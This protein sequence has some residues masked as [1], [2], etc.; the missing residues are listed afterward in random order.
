LAN[1]IEDQNKNEPSEQTKL[2]TNW[3]KVFD[4]IIIDVKEVSRVAEK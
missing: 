4:K 1:K 2:I 3:N